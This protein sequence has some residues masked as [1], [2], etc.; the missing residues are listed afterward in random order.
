MVL[1]L[2]VL[3]WDYFGESPVV[4]PALGTASLLRLALQR[5]S[6][7]RHGTACDNH[8]YACVFLWFM[9]YQGQVGDIWEYALKT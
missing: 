3:S 6:L 8:L 5:P 4:P 1:M 7:S 2:Y 9:D